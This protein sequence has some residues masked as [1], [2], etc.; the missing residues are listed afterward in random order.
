MKAII[1]DIMNEQTFNRTSQE[2]TNTISLFS[3]SEFGRIHSE[4]ELTHDDK[5]HEDDKDRFKTLAKATG[6]SL[7][8]LKARIWQGTIVSIQ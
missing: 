8:S 6:H 5:I 2:W 7:K 3:E 1:T 4:F